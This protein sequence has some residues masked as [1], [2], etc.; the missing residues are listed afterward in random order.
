MVDLL[1]S[2][3]IVFLECGSPF[4]HHI[5]AAAKDMHR[6]PFYHAYK[7]DQSLED[8]H[9]Y[10]TLK[11]ENGHNQYTMNNN[12]LT[13]S[14]YT[15][16]ASACEAEDCDKDSQGYSP[17]N[18]ILNLQKYALQSAGDKGSSAA[19][20]TKPLPRFGRACESSSQVK[21]E[22]ITQRI[23]LSSSSPQARARTGI[24]IDLEDPDEQ[25]STLPPKKKRKVE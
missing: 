7:P 25:W 15:A 8:L 19:T 9:S 3:V 4:I 22:R 17:P 23:R 6:T 10:Q 20:R 12:M 1:S 2:Y 11:H 5:I 24:R 21:R 18:R 13:D 14:A 16:S